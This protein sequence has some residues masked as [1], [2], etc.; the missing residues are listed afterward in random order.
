VKCATCRGACCE[1]AVVGSTNFA[2]RF[3]E[4][5]WLAL[6]DTPHGGC[7]ELS[8]EGRCEIYGDRPFLCRIYPAGGIDCLEVVKNRRTPEQ[9][10]QIRDVNDPITIHD[11]F[12]LP[13][14]VD[15]L[16]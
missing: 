6:H 10:Q 1:A 15:Q 11:G 12:A 4:R 5:R 14:R 9:Y 7:R 3:I 8:A 2:L 16:W 13:E